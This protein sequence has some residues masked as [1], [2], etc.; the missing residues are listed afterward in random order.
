M[1][2]MYLIAPDK[3]GKVN[4]NI[5]GHF[6]EHIGG[7][8][9]DGLWSENDR[10]ETVKGFRKE[11]VDGLKKIKAPVIRWP[12]G[13]YAET[14]RWRDG[15]GSP[16]KR[17]VRSSW[18]TSYDG[19][20]E[21][22]KVGT[23][24]FINLCREVGAE[25]YIAAN[26]TSQTPL[27]MR[28]WMD[29]CNSPAGVNALAKEREENGSREP[30]NVKFWGV[31]NE[32]W[33]GGGA[34]TPEYYGLEYRRYSKLCNNLCADAKL[35]ACGPNEEDYE[36]TRK[37]LQTIKTALPSCQC[38]D[39]LSLHYYCFNLEE[40]NPVAFD[41]NGWYRVLWQAVHTDEV[42]K[43][44][45][46][47]IKGEFMEQKAS[48]VIDEWGCWHKDGSGPSHGYNLYEQ[49]STLRDAAVTAVSLNIFNNNCDKIQMANVAQLVNNLHCLY[50][51]AGEE[52]VATPTYYVFDMFKEHQDAE[53]IRCVLDPRETIDV[54]N[55]S[56][57]KTEIPEISISATIKCN[58]IH[59]TLVNL[60]YDKE[61]EI[62][63]VPV[64]FEFI[65]EAGVK[66]VLSNEDLCACNTFEY[67]T[68]VVP[69]SKKFSFNDKLIIPAG[70]IAS[71]NLPVK[72]I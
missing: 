1:K 35:F 23:A 5:Y 16:E 45:W 25:P 40:E 33:G 15:I 34:M 2:K 65:K 66:T 28:E 61:A 13:C 49:Q 47:I 46:N 26:L 50:L 21:S 37:F 63:L 7:V 14:Y 68:R 38:L 39:G 11:I 67:K 8:F 70:G 72:N 17:P 3:I 57:K 19:R 41:R 4:R 32:N 52:C 64:G 31:G 53:A 58:R 18:W 6:V 54:T 36:W 43:R 22:N 59:I 55:P 51:A 62:E 42:I 12:G 29:Y 24:E 27:D 60:S 30:F 10:V 9:Y 20:Y 44:H 69:E 71:L 48:L 56:G